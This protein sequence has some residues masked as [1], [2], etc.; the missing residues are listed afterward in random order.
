MKLNN[1]NNILYK[2]NPNWKGKTFKVAFF[3]LDHT[4]IKPLQG[5]IHAKSPDDVT[6]WHPNIP[7]KLIELYQNKYKLVVIT[8][9]SNLL[10]KPE[11]MKI[12]EGKIDFL[13]KYLFLEKLNVL[14]SV[15]SDYARK[16]NLGLFDF[17]Q[18]KTNFKFDV[19][20]S[21][22]VGD[23]AGRTE[24]KKSKL[25]SNTEGVKKDFSCSDRMWA[26]NLGIDFYTPEEFFL[27]QK[28]RKFVMPQLS[29]ELF[30]QSVSDPDKLASQ[31]EHI[32]KYSVIMLQGPPASGK[33]S[34][35]SLL[36][37][38]GYEVISQDIL[39]S[40]N[41]CVSLMKELLL[42]D[43]NHKIV[44]DNTNG[45]LAYRNSFTTYLNSQGI[46]YC[47]VSIEVSKEQS[48]FLNNFRCKLEKKER[49]SDMVIH[50]YFKYLDAPQLTEGFDKIFQIPL[51]LEF[52]SLDEITLFNQYF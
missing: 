7:E 22:M 43:K 17:L 31:L 11:K 28:P 10:D 8:N 36:Q 20:N 4:L 15:K 38:D 16:P 30:P 33:S 3:D 35:S 39:G 9:Q 46:K 12:F 29:L 19:K 37:K 47:L 1:E 21:F 41:K 34:L 14:A 13:R 50:S 52:N 48:F 27:Q 26:K 18:E 6:L 49:L 2:I 42:Q 44:L 25:N 24:I 45:K 32:K 5:R 23:A 51:V 40:K